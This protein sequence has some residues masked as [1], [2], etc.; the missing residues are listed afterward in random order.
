MIEKLI[1]N[2]IKFNRK[3]LRKT[4]RVMSAAYDADAPTGRV[5]RNIVM[6]HKGAIK[7]LTILLKEVK[8]EIKN[9]E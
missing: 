2:R 9:T 1:N 7:E 4:E 3:E 8:Q 5:L 6:Y